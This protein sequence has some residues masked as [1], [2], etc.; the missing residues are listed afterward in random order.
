M[1]PCRTALM[2]A[3]CLLF[4]VCRALETVR[5]SSGPLVGCSISLPTRNKAHQGTSAELEA[6]VSP[7]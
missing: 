1:A 5:L 3:P 2:I 7:L 6:V 4:V